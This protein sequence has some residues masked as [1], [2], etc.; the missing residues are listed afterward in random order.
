MGK[1]LILTLTFT[2]IIIVSTVNGQ[3]LT[4]EESN[5]LNRH[6]ESKN[7]TIDFTGKKV[8][9]FLKTNPWTKDQFFKDLIKKEKSNLIMVNQF[10]TLTDEQ[11]EKSGGYD[12]FIYSLSKISISKKQVGAH[13]EKLQERNRNYRRKQK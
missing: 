10:I 6:F 8:G 1:L 13:I 7:M 4:S 9:F 2:T 11:K 3:I 5:L 12:I